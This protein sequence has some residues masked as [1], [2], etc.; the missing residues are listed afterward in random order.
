MGKIKIFQFPFADGN[1]GVKHYAM[2]NWKCLNK[3]KFD[4]TFATVR[5]NLDFEN[6]IISNGADV[7]YISCSAEQDELQFVK[8]ITNTFKNGYDI[9]HLHTSFWKSFLVEEIAIKCGIPKIIVHSHS[10]CIDIED[11]IKRA[12]AEKIHNIRRNEFNTSLATD[13]CACSNAAADWLFGEQIP[14]NKI[15]IMKNAVNVDNFIFNPDI[16]K[17]YRKDLGLEGCFVIGHIGRFTYQKNHEFLIDVFFE[18]SKKNEK[19]RLLLIGDGSLKIN[20]RKKINQL[21]LENKVIFTGTRYDVNC[22][23]QAMDIFCLPSRFE[24]LPIVLIEAQTSGLKCL[25]SDLITN[26]VCI[27]KNIKQLANIKN[28]W[29]EEIS[30]LIKGY[31]RKNMYEE[32]TNSG[33]NIK[34]QIKKV[35][36]LYM[37]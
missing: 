29:I 2:N 26:E 35:E 13:F 27:T 22:L 7:K 14:R 32:I 15:K 16:R 31:E 30:N 23:L 25:A 10:T 11:N 3:E 28:V 5:K 21:G 34:E 18:V 12:E 33:Y 9:V 24:G 8:E 4:C 6:E 19:A 36:K 20:I 1:S 37:E 17:K